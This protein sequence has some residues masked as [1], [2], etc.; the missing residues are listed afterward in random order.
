M[1]LTGT[2]TPGTAGLPVTVQRRSGKGAWRDVSSTTTAAQGAVS[3]TVKPNV[4][5]E[6][7]YRLVV[8]ESGGLAQGASAR[9]VI[10]AG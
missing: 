6:F 5:G 3:V 4:A 2:V 8:P 9:I 10:T 7:G 1:T